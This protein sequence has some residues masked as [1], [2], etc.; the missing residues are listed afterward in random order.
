[1][2]GI[3]T[4]EMLRRPSFVIFCVSTLLLPLGYLV[5]LGFG[6]YP[7]G[8]AT[9][10]G[11]EALSWVWSY[12]FF[13]CAAMAVC[14]FFFLS[15]AQFE[16]VDETICSYKRHGYYQTAGLLRL[17]PVFILSQIIL[18]AGVS[19]ISVRNDGTDYFL[20]V[21]P[22]M[23]VCNLFLPMAI[24]LLVAYVCALLPN[25]R[26]AAIVMIAF[27]VM[28]SPFVE[29]LVSGHQGTHTL[30][31]K[32]R[33]CFAVFGE[34]IQWIFS[35]QVG[36]QTEWTRFGVQFFWI[37]LCLG[38]VCLIKKRK[39]CVTGCLLLACSVGCMVYAQLPASVFRHYNGH[40]DFY[41]YKDE[42]GGLPRTEEP[43]TISDY[44][45]TLNIGRQLDVTGTLVFE[46]DEPT[47]EFD[48]TLY[49]TYKVKSLESAEPITWSVED[50]I[51]T[52]RTEAPTERLE[53]DLNYAGYHDFFYSSTDG[54]LLPGWLPWYPMA[55]DNPVY[56]RY[57]WSEYNNLNRI[58][59][60]HI[61]LTIDAPFEFVTN[62]EQVSERIYE[63]VSDSIT[64]IGGYLE[65]T[66]DPV[67][68]NIFPLDLR[69]GYLAE[70]YL[71]DTKAAYQE[72][73]DTLELY[74]VDSSVVSGRK[75]IL[76]SYDLDSN[77]AGGAV[78][79]DYILATYS[80]IHSV[81]WALSQ[82]IWA[83]NTTD[84]SFW[85][86]D[87]QYQ[88]TPEQTLERWMEWINTNNPELNPPTE[89]EQEVYDIITAANA[90][91]QGEQ[92]TKDILQFLLSDHTED[93][94]IAFWEEL[95][96]QYGNT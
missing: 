55:G 25:Q 50:D 94:E 41:L 21:L 74:G 27:L 63:G 1:M 66:D 96:E 78:F 54:A 26:S 65:K 73:C 93:E 31:Y 16:D 30:G 81:Y 58:E 40:I 32:I 13:L 69:E 79:S 52:I 62:L 8:M 43:Y 17:L 68:A 33:H 51:V 92:L 80:S 87:M 64:L 47:D 90:A 15:S 20:S 12:W 28:T 18:Y 38:A 95:N 9:N 36:I 4:K 37:F 75:I 23:F 45:L 53:I 39:I 84:Q 83:N 76:A 60:A 56:V 77:G 22:K 14:E 6:F 72:M 91:G 85:I 11:I 86:A 89:V 67:I 42:A 44:D 88:K 7:G 3:Q 57:L 10:T 82:M 19:I 59:P 70:Q 2:N 46:A 49:H 71:A 35:S 24:C 61:R 34:E 5:L 29:V 48:L